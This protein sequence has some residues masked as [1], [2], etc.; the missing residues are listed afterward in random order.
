[1]VQSKQ[2]QVGAFGMKP[3]SQ[4][5]MPSTE[6]FHQYM[7]LQSFAQGMFIGCIMLVP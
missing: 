4:L 5:S 6:I 2:L 7:K 1:M 3:M